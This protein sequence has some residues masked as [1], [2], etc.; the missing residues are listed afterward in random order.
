MAVNR[1][2]SSRP[3]ALRLLADGLLLGLLLWA[4]VGWF[5]TAFSLP[6]DPLLLYGGLTLLTLLSLTI[7]S[8]PLRFGMPLLFLSSLLWGQLVW[9]IWEDLFA[10]QAAIQCAVVNTYSEHFPGLSRLVPVMERTPEQ[11]SWAVT[12]TVLAAAAVYAVLLGLL[13]VRLRSC[14]V[15]GLAV[16]VPVIPALPLGIPPVLWLVLLLTGWGGLLLSAH[17]AREDPRRAARLTLAA[18]PLVGITLSL[19]TLLVPAAGYQPP[20]W[21]KDGRDTLFQTVGDLSLSLNWTGP[22]GR[23]LFSSAGSTATVDLSAAGTQS[24]D[25]HTVLRIRTDYTGKLYLRGYSAALYQ[26]NRWTP[27]EE[28]AY[29]SLLSD[30]AVVDST[31]TSSGLNPLNFPARAEADL[32]Y[33]AFEVEQVSAPG[34]CVYFPYQILSRPEELRGASFQD[35]SGIIRSPLVGKHTVY[36][37]PGALEPDAAPPLEWQDALAEQEYQAFVQQH[38]LQVPDDL[39]YALS[40]HVYALSDRLFQA[41]MSSSRYAFYSAYDPAR[42]PQLAAELVAE[43]LAELAEYDL[44]TPPVPDG[45]D[46]TLYFLN[47]SHRGYCMHFASAGTLLLRSLGIPARYVSGYVTNVKTPGSHS[48]PDRAAHA[49]VE[50]YLSGYGWYPVEMTPGYQ[51]DAL[52]WSQGES[53]EPVSTPSAT[54]KPTPTPKP[55]AA[56]V[57]TPRPTA[58]TPPAQTQ[59]D[60]GTGSLPGWLLPVGIL[61]AVCFLPILIRYITGTLRRRRLRQEDPHRAMVSIYRYAR[62]LSRHGGTLPPLVEELAQKAAFSRDGV[63]LEECRLARKAASAEAERFYRSCPWWKRLLLRWFWFLC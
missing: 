35:D 19:L 1:S 39:F 31:G 42:A 32:P 52:P 47:E 60:G 45:E 36:F 8:L 27:L 29:A 34:G 11:W 40:P 48:V 9:R 59:D 38:Y 49:W 25:G 41:Q 5:C 53:E 63:T 24:Y 17:S 56:P 30:G 33:Y 2:S 46:F 14:W 3:S 21:V 57:Q 28:D 7:F 18:L 58:S 55:S 26:D 23:S 16:L 12:L 6:V 50:I 10:G 20:A 15:S 62:R 4:P 13:V 44:E 61:L 54:P 43:Y 22:F 37:R 51:G